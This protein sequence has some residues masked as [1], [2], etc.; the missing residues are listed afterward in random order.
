[1]GCDVYLCVGL[2]ACVCCL[3][4][5]ERECVC[6][7]V[8]T[9]R[10]F[11]Y[12]TVISECVRLYAYECVCVCV[13]VC[14]VSVCVRVCMC[15]PT[16]RIIFLSDSF[17]LDPQIAAKEIRGERKLVQV[18]PIATRRL[19]ARDIILFSLS[20]SLSHS[21]S[22]SLSLVHAL[23]SY[24]PLCTQSLA[25]CLSQNYLRVIQRKLLY[26]RGFSRPSVRASSPLRIVDYLLP[27][28]AARTLL[29]NI[30]FFPIFPE[31][32][33]LPLKFAK[34]NML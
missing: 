17:R 23:S 14:C 2:C 22:L 15:V 13:F 19:G 33:P 16:C 9:C 12:A 32:S 5:C 3:S 6:L 11:Y 25:H 26:R 29:A 1:M 7:C 34:C 8:P 31:V 24:S 21:R 27:I 20:L 30:L 28:Y 10:V 4:V 18:P